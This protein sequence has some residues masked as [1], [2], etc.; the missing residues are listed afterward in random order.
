MYFTTFGL[1]PSDT[2]MELLQL[3]VNYHIE[4][5]VDAHYIM[6]IWAVGVHVDVC[7]GCMGRDL[8]LS[9]IK[10]SPAWLSTVFCV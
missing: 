10:S 9:L 1:F 6:N 3:M 4:T 5:G 8:L 7:G 2:G